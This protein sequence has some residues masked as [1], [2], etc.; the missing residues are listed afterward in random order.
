MFYALSL[1]VFA[2]GTAMAMGIAWRFGTMLA[3]SIVL[4]WTPELIYWL[5]RGPKFDRSRV[6]V[7][8]SITLPE[9]AAEV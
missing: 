8:H 2:V 1:C 7:T 3:D 6:E 9:V 4:D 5:R